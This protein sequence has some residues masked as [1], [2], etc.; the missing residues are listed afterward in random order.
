M[1]VKHP[2]SIQ[3]KIQRVELFRRSRERGKGHL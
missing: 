3:D 1:W 2:L